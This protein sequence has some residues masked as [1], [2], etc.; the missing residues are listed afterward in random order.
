MK[1]AVEVEFSRGRGITKGATLSFAQTH[2]SAS[3]PRRRRRRHRRH[4]AHCFGRMQRLTSAASEAS[5]WQ[6]FGGGAEKARA[7]GRAR[8][9]EGR[10][11]VWTGFPTR[12]D[13]RAVDGA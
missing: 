3:F 6:A 12:Y 7:R 5:E 10:L 4:R 1:F 13:G 2:F 9:E 8:E 11:N